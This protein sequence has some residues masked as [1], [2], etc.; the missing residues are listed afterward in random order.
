MSS[1]VPSKRH[2]REILLYCFNVKKNAREAHDTLVSAYG[3][4]ALSISQCERWFKKFVDGDFELDN[5]IRENAPKRFEDTELQAL[6]E[7][8]DT[9]TQEELA[10]QLQ[11][12][13]ST[14]SRRLTRMGLIQ[15]LSQWVP[16]KLSERQQERRLTT[17]TLLLARHERKP[18]LYRIVTGD[19]KW[20][21]FD[22]PSV[23]NHG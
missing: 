4:H 9:Q 3:E 5:K 12:D 1:F 8:D 7:K 22:N 23:R 11:V 10:G 6:L 16:H 18:F 14:I 2:L 19:E 21:F 17:C 13:H 20:I 15:K